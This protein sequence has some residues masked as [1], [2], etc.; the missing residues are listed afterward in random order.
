MI[1]KEQLTT[2][3]FGLGTNFSGS[4]AILA[5]NMSVKLLLDS[6]TRTGIESGQ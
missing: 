5:L 2:V 6:E 4:E 1:D 3:W